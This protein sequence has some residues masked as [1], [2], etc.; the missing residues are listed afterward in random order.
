MSQRIEL[1]ATSTAGLEGV[2]KQEVM[3][4]G[5][6]NAQ[7]ENGKVIYTTDYKG[8]ARSNLWLRTAD[9]V[10]WK[11]AEFKAVTFE[12]LF[13]QT[14][15]LPWGEI[16]PKNAHFPVLGRSVK[17]TLFSISD[18]Q[19][20]VKKA[21][22]ENMKEKYNVS[23]FDED[24]PAYTIEVSL[25]KDIATITID[26]SGE[27]LHKRG[28]RRLHNVAPLKETMAAALIQISRWKP[29]IPFIDPFCGSG[30]LAIEAALIG[31]NIAPG[32]N[33]SFDAEEWGILPQKIW[34]DAIEEAEDLAEYNRN[35]AIFASDIDDESVKLTENNALEAGVHHLVQA[36]QHDF[37][38]VRSEYEYG[39]MITNPP[40]G[41]RIGDKE[42]TEAL[43][44]T[45]GRLTKHYFDTWSVYVLTPH[46][47]FE[48]LFGRKANKKRKLFS[49]NIRVDYYQYFGPRPPKEIL[50]REL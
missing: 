26:T 10:K 11:L 40:Y 35:L 4:L 43:Y 39:Y 48:T 27:G 49:G 2:V 28:Y 50:D 23:W 46:Q 33:R 24:G 22:V 12:E 3:D 19:A 16:L 32:F 34:D 21:I 36:S 29:N 20:I 6:K 45:L 7:A 41:E 47:Q 1:I 5:Y 13:Q 42:E 38:D 37:K 14:K 15:A 44:R 31:Q 30:T 9:R 8:I 17:S 25:L 18:S